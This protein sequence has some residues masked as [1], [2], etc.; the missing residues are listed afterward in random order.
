MTREYLEA[1]IGYFT[2]IEDEEM[3]KKIIKNYEDDN[4]SYK[5]AYLV[6]KNDFEGKATGDVFAVL[7]YETSFTI[8]DLYGNVET[9]D[10]DDVSERYVYVCD[11]AYYFK[12]CYRYYDPK[13]YKLF[14]PLWV[15]ICSTINRY[16][17]NK[18]KFLSCF[19]QNN[20]SV[21]YDIVQ[22]Y[23][24][25]LKTDS[26]SDFIKYHYI[27][28]LYFSKINSVRDFIKYHKL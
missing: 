28:K 26:V 20:G 2:E 7:D 22:E 15:D 14:T 10:V 17:L 25:C 4:A 13:F 27:Y 1:I 5:E 9:Y 6:M 16:G 3:L 23:Y 19:K 12:D 24:D 8:I 21:N 18:E 11:I